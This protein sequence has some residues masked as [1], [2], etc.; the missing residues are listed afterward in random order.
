[1]RLVKAYSAMFRRAF[2]NPGWAISALIWTAFSK[3]G[4]KF[5]VVYFFAIIAAGIWLGA[6]M[7]EMGIEPK[8]L[9]ATVFDIAFTLSI[10]LFP[11]IIFAPLVLLHFGDEPS[12]THGSARFAT[13]KEVAPLTRADS[14]LLIGRDSKTGK[15]LRY[16]GPAHLLTMAPTRTG[17]GVGTIIPNLL[18]ADRS[19]ICI[20]PKGENAR[21]AGR[22]REKFG[23]VHILDPFGVAGRPSAA[24]NPLNALDPYGI[25]VAEDAS[26]LADALVFDE[27]GMAGEAH[28]NEEAKALIAGLI[29]NIVA[30][31]PSGRRHLGTLREY[32]TLAPDSF[33]ALLKRMQDSTDINGL[34]ARAANRHLGK[35]D[36]EG[37]G[38]LSAAQR[39]T[40][41]LDSPRMT[42][43]LGRSDFTFADLKT[44]NATVFLVL[45]PD[46]LSTYS[47]WLRLLVT[48]SL[49]DMARDPARP[50][51]PVLYLLDEFAALGHLAPVERAM[52]LMAGY[53]VQLWPI[54]QDVHQLRATYGQRAGT[55]LSNAGVLQI[56]GVND[57]DSARLVSDL[58]GQETVV[59]Q[60][61]ARALDSENSGIS[62]SQHHTARPLLTPD[63][64]RNLPQNLELLFL[65]GQ[66][67][68]V[69]AKLAYY[70]DPE[71]QGAFDPA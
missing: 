52:G 4:I 37:A 17:K 53:G 2:T 14:G 49:T 15:L 35:S 26:T 29:L 59:F 32:L 58:L 45:P 64:V 42:T 40:H 66:R 16:E 3:K 5:L 55:F 67:S 69:A 27:P 61:M 10:P 62:V 21:I 43:V 18:T 39:H 20:D 54:L 56:F 71:F 8:S 12:D 13:P 28:W 44:R 19:V 30:V 50:A 24:F 38:V 9:V 65:A 46:R 57:H 60:T 25:D 68:I 34:I 36:R 51:V 63:E 23:P 41:F 48:Q 31:E 70:A 22:A 6:K 33:A 7:G 1:M 11:L 47:R